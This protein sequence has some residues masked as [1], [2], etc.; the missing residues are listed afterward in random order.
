MTALDPKRK[1]G[2][3]ISMSDAGWWRSVGLMGEP[4]RLRQKFGV[5]RKKHT[6]HSER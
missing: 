6:C 3:L 2:Y 4:D 5:M 1:F